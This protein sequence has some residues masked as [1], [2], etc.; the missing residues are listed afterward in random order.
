MGVVDHEQKIL[1][2]IFHATEY[3]VVENHLMKLRNVSI[4]LTA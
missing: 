2:N 3:L 1:K 4:T